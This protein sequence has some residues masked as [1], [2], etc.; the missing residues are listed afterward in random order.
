M[1]CYALGDARARWLRSHGVRVRYATAFDAFGLPH[2]AAAAEAGTPTHTYVNGQI[3]RIAGQLHD[4]GLSYDRHDHPRTCEPSYYRWTQWLFLAL[5]R[6]GLVHTEDRV[7]PFCEGCSEYL[8]A[9]QIEQ[10]ECWRCAGPVSGRSSE[11]WF[12]RSSAYS[13]ALAA[14]TDE[15]V[16]WSPRSRNLMHAFLG[17]QEGRGSTV[18]VETGDTPVEFDLF[19]PNGTELK[20]I[21]LSSEHALAAMVTDMAAPLVSGKRGDSTVPRLPVCVLELPSGPVSLYLRHSADLP[22]E[23]DAISVDREATDVSNL[24][25]FAARQSPV[26]P[27]VRFRARDWLV[28]RDRE[29]GTPLPAVQCEQCGIAPVAE[30]DLPLLLPVHGGDGMACCSGCGTRQP[31]VGRRLDCF[32]DDSWCFWAAHPSW[33][34][35]QNPFEL[36]KSAPPRS[37]FFHSGYDSFVYLYLYRIIGRALLDLGLVQDPEVVDRFPGHDVVTADGRK[38]S[39]RHGNAPDLDELLRKEGPAVV[40]LAVL[41][42]ANPGKPIDWSDDALIRARRLVRSAGRLRTWDPA[43]QAGNSD[44]SLPNQIDRFLRRADQFMD[45]YRVGSAIDEVYVATRTFLRSDSQDAAIRSTLIAW[46]DCF[47][48][49]IA[50]APHAGS[51]ASGPEVTSPTDPVQRERVAVA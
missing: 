40:R 27:A 5:W 24:R 35:E 33:T 49:E 21:A 48:P 44:R 14:S 4:L 3:E 50:G 36:W 37:V 31:T 38:M 16:N 42:N 18:R 7:L 22:H 34:P 8:A 2:E 51:S 11:Q 47:A 9:S 13:E 46:W 6:L 45:E 32:L 28:S 43:G 25:R 30:A 15:L 20:G 26:S 23:T 10:G 17:R 19:V 39:K 41:A 12:I 29:W 1:R